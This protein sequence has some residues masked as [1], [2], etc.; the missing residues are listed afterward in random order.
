M[1][2]ACVY[3]RHSGG[4]GRYIFPLL[5]CKILKG[6]ERCW[7]STYVAI[8]QACRVLTYITSINLFLRVSV[9]EKRKKRKKKKKKKDQW[10]SLVT[11]KKDGEQA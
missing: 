1:S 9:S 7:Y 10:I 5:P 11:Q 2:K 6:V 4:G 8:D 3:L